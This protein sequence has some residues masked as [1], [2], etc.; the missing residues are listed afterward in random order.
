MSGGVLNATYSLIDTVVAGFCWQLVS[1]TV[2]SCHTPLIAVISSKQ[3]T[4]WM[5]LI[6]SVI[7][8]TLHVSFLK[9]FLVV[10]NDIHN[11]DSENI[12]CWHWGCYATDGWPL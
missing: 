10:C 12:Y 4:S 11:T 9:N 7:V 6:V 1:L 8:I 3:Q 2:S 5:V